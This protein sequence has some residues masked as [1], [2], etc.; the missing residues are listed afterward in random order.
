MRGKYSPT[1]STAYMKDQ[2]WWS[3][4]AAENVKAGNYYDP[5]G[6]DSYGYDVN[7]VDRAGNH[8]STYYCDDVDDY[9]NSLGSNWRYDQ[10]LFDWTFDGVR[11]VYC[12]A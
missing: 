12:G 8:E 11:P 10:A 4:Y 2:E 3:R 6:F 5:D 7:D 9:D 1:V